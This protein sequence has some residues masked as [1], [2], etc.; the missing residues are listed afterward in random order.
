MFQSIW[1]VA[2]AFCQHEENLSASG[3]IIAPQH[4]FGHHQT[5]SC[6]TSHQD[7]S[8][9]QS[10]N[11]STQANTF[12]CDHQNHLPSFMH[13]I[14]VNVQQSVETLQSFYAL[15]SPHYHWL[16]A[17]QSPDLYRLNPPPQSSL[18]SVG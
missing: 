9:Q 2:A 12:S 7:D 10:S 6:E 1:N 4:H 13:L 18:L 8:K 16:N 17:Y 3:I 5:I 11:S 14:L 15:E